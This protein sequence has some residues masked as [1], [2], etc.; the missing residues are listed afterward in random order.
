MLISFLIAVFLFLIGAALGSFINVFVSRTVKGENW[1]FGRS[2][3]DHC[4]KTIRWYHNLPLFSF[5]VLEGKAACC[6]KPLSLTHPVVELITGALFVWWYFIG[7]LFFRLTQAPFQ[8]LQPLFW[9][10]VGFILLAILVADLL[11]YLIPDSL[12]LTLVVLVLGYRLLLLSFGIMQPQ[13]F[14]GMIISTMVLTFIFL[15]L[16]IGTKGKGFGFGDVKFAVPMGLLLGW[17]RI[18]VAFFLAF[19]IGALVGIVLILLGKKK[20]G[21]IIPFGPFLVLATVLSL[22][23]G[24]ALYS[25]YIGLLL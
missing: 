3:C 12:V 8:T 20:F 23:F 11:Y 9:L 2:Y 24:D 15:G 13:D 18:V 17:P 25:W 21:Q 16:H 5:L 1:I 19:S 22:L 6:K 10:L 4:N 7:S 14:F